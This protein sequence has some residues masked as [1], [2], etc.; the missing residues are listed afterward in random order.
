M[1][2]GREKE[3]KK[4]DGKRMVKDWSYRTNSRCT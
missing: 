1:E 3:G 4:E 2:E